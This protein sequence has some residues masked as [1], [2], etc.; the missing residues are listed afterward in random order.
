MNATY[1]TPTGSQF[2]QSDC[3]PICPR[4]GCLMEETDRVAENGSLYIWYECSTADC[5]EQWLS[6]KPALTA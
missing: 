1:S 3:A 6:K 5:D 2:R 4:C